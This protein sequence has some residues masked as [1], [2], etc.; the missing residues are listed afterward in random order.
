MSTPEDTRMG[1][2][3]LEAYEKFQRDR[4]A[5]LKACKA[6][7]AQAEKRSGTQ[8]A[9]IQQDARDAIAQAERRT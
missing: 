5:L 4:D 9:G 1:Y 6:L 3:S 8:R 2:V 7:L